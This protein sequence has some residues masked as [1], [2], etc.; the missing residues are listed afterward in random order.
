MPQ[1]TLAVSGGSLL[2]LIS[3][4]TAEQSYSPP[5]GHSV[6]I[7]YQT[8]PTR[9]EHGKTSQVDGWSTFFGPKGQQ[10]NPCA[11]LPFSRVHHTSGVENSH[12]AI[13]NPPFPRVGLRAG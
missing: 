6:Q 10:V 11:I 2:H 8:C 9:N 13:D 12:V 7:L 5:I 4:L 1:S 3:Q